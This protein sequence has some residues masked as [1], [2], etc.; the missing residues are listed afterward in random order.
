MV[1]IFI[2]VSP[3]LCE[4]SRYAPVHLQPLAHTRLE[5]YVICYDSCDTCIVDT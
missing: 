1:G 2:G 4:H 5:C 3:L